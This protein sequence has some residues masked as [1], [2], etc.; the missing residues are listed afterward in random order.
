MKKKNEKTYQLLCD[1]VCSRCRCSPG[2]PP[3]TIVKSSIGR[4]A[5]ALFKSNS[6]SRRPGGRRLFVFFRR[7]ACFTLLARFARNYYLNSGSGFVLN[8]RLCT[9]ILASD[10]VSE[11]GYPGAGHTRVAIET[12]IFIVS[13]VLVGI[14]AVLTFPLAL[15]S[16]GERPFRFGVCYSILS[17]DASSGSFA[18]RLVVVSNVLLVIVCVAT[19][20]CN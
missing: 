5:F 14:R 7:G 8:D 4:G 9:L 10:C 19:S 2:G 11:S 15:A 13:L 16:S 20:N 18:R 6:L 1:L 17:H 12:L 3:G